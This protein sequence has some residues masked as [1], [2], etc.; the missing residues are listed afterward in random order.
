M[1]ADFSVRQYGAEG[2]HSC[3]PNGG[4][5]V[6]DISLRSEGTLPERGSVFLRWV[7]SP[8]PVGVVFTFGEGL[9]RM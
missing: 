3:P 9:G 6:L 1:C 4:L 5:T 8:A 7:E 2:G